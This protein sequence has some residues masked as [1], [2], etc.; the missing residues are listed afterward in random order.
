MVSSVSYPSFKHFNLDRRIR[1]YYIALVPLFLIAIALDPPTMLLSIF[2]TYAVSA[3][4]LWV[5]RRLRRLRRGPP[6]VA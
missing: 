6:P 5:V 2:G 1:F 4:L 3:P